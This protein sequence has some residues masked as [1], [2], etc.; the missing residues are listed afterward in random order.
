[1]LFLKRNEVHNYFNKIKDKFQN[2]FP[3][4]IK[5]FE[6]NFFKK[7]PMKELDWNYDVER[8]NLI[9]LNHYFFTNNICESTNRT[10][11]MNYKGACKSILSF[12][13]AILS[14]IKLYENK[15]KYVDFTFSVS[16]AIAFI[17]QLMKY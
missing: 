9:D 8:N 7:Y 6:Y 16:R 17:L 14:L 5:Y 13:N 10:L 3:K 15:K 4:F 12:E 2:D 11:N 1:M